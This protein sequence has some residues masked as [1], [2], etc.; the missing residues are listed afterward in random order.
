MLPGRKAA[1]VR[2]SWLSLVA[3]DTEVPE[4]RLESISEYEKGMATSPL[5]HLMFQP[6]LK[7]PP[8]FLGVFTSF[9]GA[10]GR[11]KC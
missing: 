1:K 5:A 9:K 4:E 6:D 10:R 3:R 2:P 11:R 7:W 8:V